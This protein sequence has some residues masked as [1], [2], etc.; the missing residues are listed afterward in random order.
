MNRKKTLCLIL[1]I[2]VAVAIP[3]TCFCLLR[4]KGTG[5]P[6]ESDTTPGTGETDTLPD[7]TDTT[8]EPDTIP[9]IG[10]EKHEAESETVHI[11]L[12]VSEITRNPDAEV[13][14]GSI[15]YDTKEVPADAE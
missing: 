11:D 1:T 10:G 2:A 5:T 6:A 15:E 3:M 13:I 8:V 9:A 7:A 12:D 14:D 4:D